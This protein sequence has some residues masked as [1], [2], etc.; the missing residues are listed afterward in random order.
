MNKNLYQEL[1]EFYGAILVALLVCIPI[2]GLLAIAS[3]RSVKQG[4]LGAFLLALTPFC[5]Y[6]INNKILK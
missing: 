4:L 5:S 6:I 3:A 1:K 2:A